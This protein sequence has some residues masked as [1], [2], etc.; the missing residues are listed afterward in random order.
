MDNQ[1][2]ACGLPLHY[3]DPEK[4]KIVEQLI[5]MCG[6]MVIITNSETGRTWKVPRHFIALHGLKMIEMPQLA[7]QYGFEEINKKP[8]KQDGTPPSRE[9]SVGE[10]GEE[11]QT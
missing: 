2:C 7:I 4:R 8:I 11:S 5:A 6:E 1:M 3:R 9:G 10:L